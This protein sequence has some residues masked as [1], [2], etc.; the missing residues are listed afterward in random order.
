[1]FVA[2]ARPRGTVA[3]VRFKSESAQ[4]RGM[5]AVVGCTECGNL[6]LLSDPDE[7]DSAQCSRCGTRHRTNKL[8]RFFESADRDEARQARSALLADKQDAGDVF[9]ELDPVSEMEWRL[10]DSGV[11]DDEYLDGVGLDAD[12]VRQ[13][14]EGT[15]RS[16]EPGSRDEVVRAALREQH[17][18]S[19]SEVVAYAEARG[20]PAD[21][22]RDLLDKLIRRGE[23]S[24]SRGRYRLL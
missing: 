14:G 18:P 12:E 5:Y 1:M 21:A 19:E 3:V 7:A 24:E 16:G 20:V 10:D 8:R 15:T 11:S 13:A 22:A 23:V 4:P 17:R 6:W 2:V 9:A